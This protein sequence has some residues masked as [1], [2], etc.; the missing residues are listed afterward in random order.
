MHERN[1]VDS[2]KFTSIHQSIGVAPQ[3]AVSMAMIFKGPGMRMLN[4]FTE[5]TPDII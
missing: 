2:I 3:D 4:D 1:H 5:G